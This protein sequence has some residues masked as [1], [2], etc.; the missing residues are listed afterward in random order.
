VE[1]QEGPF[2]FLQRESD[3]STR[4]QT[5]EV[6]MGKEHQAH[7]G[8]LVIRLLSRLQQMHVVQ[9]NAEKP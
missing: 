2:H 6:A 1:Q 7:L 3:S 9:P 8:W 4:L 5:L